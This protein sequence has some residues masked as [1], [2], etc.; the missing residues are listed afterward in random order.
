MK[1]DDYQK[2]VLIMLYSLFTLS[3]IGFGSIVFLAVIGRN[4]MSDV[5]IFIIYTIYLI[6]ILIKYN[7]YKKDMLKK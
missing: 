3:A 2:A 4:L 5:V 1:L 7:M 6:F